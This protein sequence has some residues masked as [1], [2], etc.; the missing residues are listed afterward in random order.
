MFGSAGLWRG[1]SPTRQGTMPGLQA[2]ASRWH[3]GLPHSRGCDSA[4]A[5]WQ[6][7]QCG[8]ASHLELSLRNPSPLQPLKPQ[9]GFRSRRS[10]ATARVR[11]LG[12][13]P[14]A[15]AARQE[16]SPPLP[17]RGRRQ[18]ASQPAPRSRHSPRPGD[19]GRA[20]LCFTCQVSWVRAPVTAAQTA[21][22]GENK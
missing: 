9:K 1:G 6:F 11:R 13:C 18:R 3:V 2:V 20:L 5:G 21:S 16:A 14:C 7:S 22:S 4:G 17:S 12:P 15:R 10:N 19:F 8:C